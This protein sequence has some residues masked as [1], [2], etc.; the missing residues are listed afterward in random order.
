MSSPRVDVLLPVYCA[1]DTL[2]DAVDDALGQIGVEVRLI[3]VVDVPSTGDDGS[4]AWLAERARRDDRLVVLEGPGRGVGAAL[5]VGLAAVTTPW[6]AHMEAD[7]RCQPDRLSRQLAARDPASAAVTCRVAQSG[8]R[9]PGMARYLGWQNALLSHEE[10][11]RE[12]WVE[13]PAMHQTGL[14]RT[15]AVRECGGY[16]PR[17]EWPADIDF[18]FRW[19]EPPARDAAPRPTSKLP[20]VLY[21]WRQHAGQ[22]TRRSPTHA[23][24]V[25]RESKAHYLAR[26][27]GPRAETP[28]AV[29]LVSTGRT[30][31]AWAGALKRARI[32]IA[33]RTSWRPMDGLP[34]EVLAAAAGGCLI[35]AAYGHASTRQRVRERVVQSGTSLRE[36]DD[37]LFTA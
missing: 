25:L 1:R 35:L 26:R 18:W 20:R 15:S 22:S 12:R 7:D 33:G 13:I 9:T 6:F 3:T 8:A 37:L 31:A 28:R 11:A 30:L 29:H 16:A 4:A 17:G 14:Y 27:V 23:L 5:D 2:P 21:H 10:M 19:F 24:S 32:E 36:P 34:A